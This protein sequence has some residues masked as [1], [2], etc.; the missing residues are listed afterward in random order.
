V[1]ILYL[2]T[3][4]NWGGAQRHVYDLATKMKELGHEVKVAV[5]GNG[6][7]KTR[8]ESAGIFTYS[9]DMLGRDM[10]IGKDTGSFREIFSIIKSQKPDILHLHSPKA[11]GLGALSGRIFGVKKIIMTV[12]GWTW[13][14]SRPL[15]ERAGIIIAS[16]LTSLLCHRIVVICHKDYNQALRLPG[17]KNKLILIPLGIKSL[18]LVSVDGAKQFI[19]KTINMEVSEFNKRTV[20]GTIAELHPNKGFLFLIEAMTMIVKKFPD[21]LCII[22][23]DGEQKTQLQKVI[24]DKQ[25]EKH[26]LLVGNVEDAAQYLKALSIFIL[27]SIKEGLSYVLLEAGAASVPIVTTTVGGNSDIVH[28]M[29]SGILVQSGNSKDLAHAIMFSLEHPKENRE[30]AAKLRERINTTFSLQRMID[31]TLRVYIGQ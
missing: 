23:G 5:G 12:H 4:S 30:F 24:I 3:K 14:E 11:S 19:A 10:S 2:I 21:I 16:W 20:I 13:N 9:V 15:Y 28:D 18:P 8:L 25:L 17:L 1:K 26:V 22:I 29:E 31:A 27:P 6:I 7:L